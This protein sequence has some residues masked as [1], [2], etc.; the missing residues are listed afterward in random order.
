MVTQNITQAA[1]YFSDATQNGAVWPIDASN[2]PIFDLN[3]EVSTINIPSLAS[4]SSSRKIPKPTVRLPPVTS[5]P[6]R[7]SSSAYFQKPVIGVSPPAS[8]RE[9]VKSSSTEGIE[10]QNYP[11]YVSQVAKGFASQQP[12]T[13]EK[14]QHCLAKLGLETGEGFTWADDPDLP[15]LPSAESKPKEDLVQ[16]SHQKGLMS[17]RWATQD[18][19]S[20]MFVADNKPKKHIPQQPKEGSF[21]GLAN[22]RWATQENPSSAP[23]AVRKVK[24][25][26]QKRH[27]KPFKG[28]SSSRWATE[29]QPQV[30]R[31]TLSNKFKR[32][33]AQCGL[34][35]PQITNKSSLP[36]RPS[37]QSAPKST[38]HPPETSRI[39][40]NKHQWNKKKPARTA[41]RNDRQK[42]ED[43]KE[44]G[45]EG[46]YQGP[47]LLMDWEEFDRE[48]KQYGLK[49]LKDSRWADKA[50]D[51]V[52]GKAEDK[53]ED[54]EGK[55]QGPGLLMDWEEFD[56][57]VKQYGLKTLKHS[58]WA[59]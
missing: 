19:P 10:L 3:L 58:R 8:F 1:M 59:N 32:E 44:E 43:T 39:S 33:L 6:S 28:L 4:T 35:S 12:E 41:Y 14:V 30:D 24:D 51:K 2:M 40:T 15:S 18:E 49:T 25:I 36:S 54:K 38:I 17:S 20:Q 29:N 23:V 9:A 34:K 26:P 7:D 22:S 47:G 16:Q 55:Y 45:K 57:E 5:M 46:K 27:D 52:E 50:E 21:K 37:Y 48:V 56:R 11:E 42:A 53:A 31:Q 13:G